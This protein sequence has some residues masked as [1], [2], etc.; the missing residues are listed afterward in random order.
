MKRKKLGVPIQIFA[1]SCDIIP[2]PQK[3]TDFLPNFNIFL[4]VTKN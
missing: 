1:L 2:K 3:Y 4:H